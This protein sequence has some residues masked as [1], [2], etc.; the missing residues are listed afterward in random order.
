MKICGFVSDAVIFSSSKAAAK[1]SLSASSSGFALFC[2]A[3]FSSSK[4]AI[5]EPATGFISLPVSA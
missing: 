2:G 3:E 1:F 5:L 4:K